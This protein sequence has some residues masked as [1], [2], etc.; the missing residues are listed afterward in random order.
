M[1][2]QQKTTDSHVEDNIELALQLLI[3][4]MCVLPGVLLTFLYWP[5]TQYLA[6]VWR[7]DQLAVRYQYEK[8]WLVLVRYLAFGACAVSMYYAC[9]IAPHKMLWFAQYA[10][11]VGAVCVTLFSGLA[12]STVVWIEKRHAAPDIQKMVAGLDAEVYVKG[13]IERLQISDPDWRSLHGALLVFE[14][15]TPAEFSVEIDHLFVTQHNCYLI[16]TKYRNA[17]VSALDK[18]SEWK[19]SALDG[20]Q[21]QMRNALLQAKKA[22]RVLEQ[23]YDLPCRVI[24]LVAIHGAETVIVDGPANVVRSDKL[25]D[26]IYAFEETSRA[27]CLQPSEIVKKVVACL[28]TDNASMQ[29]HIERA[30]QARRSSEANSIVSRSSLL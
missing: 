7:L 20:R 2:R 23:R 8:D 14:R 12:Y 24:P 25:L 28:A 27:N 30:N 4:V 3:Y 18:A 17:T 13:V 26:L 22:A 5:L 15:G 1:S 19:T 29:R 16:E 10:L 21:G 11:T 9:F 6:K